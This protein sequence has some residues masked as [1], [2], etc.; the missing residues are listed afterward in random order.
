[1]DP[2]YTRVSFVPILTAGG[3]APAVYTVASGAIVRG[4]SYAIG[5]D[6][7]PGGNPGVFA[8]AC[9]TN[10]VTAGKT[11]GGRA[12]EIQGISCQFTPFNRSASLAANLF[13]NTSMRLLFNGSETNILLGPLYMVPGGNGFYSTNGE[14]LSQ[15]P[16]IPG[17]KSFFG[18]YTNGLPGRDNVLKIREGIIWQPEG[19]SDSSLVIQLTPERNIS[20]QAPANEAA[21]AGIRG[22]VQPTAQAMT[23]DLMLQLHGRIVG[24][25]SHIV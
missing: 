20:V 12:V 6:M 13:T 8:Q 2:Y 1:M 21:A 22:Y 16:A 25:R 17:G 3:A 19:E 4:F 15:E 24:P 14:D 18:A 11:I 5:S 23:V 10:I 9:D 7:G